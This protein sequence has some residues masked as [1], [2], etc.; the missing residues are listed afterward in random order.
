MKIFTCT[1]H[2]SHYPVG[3]ASVIVAKDRR[4]AKR[5]LDA[6]LVAEGLKPWKEEKYTLE[7][8]PLHYKH[9]VILNN[10]EY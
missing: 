5:L 7:E 4:E 8:L 3:V 2:D 9:A 6:E 10:G 1:D